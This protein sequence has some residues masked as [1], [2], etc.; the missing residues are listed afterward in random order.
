MAVPHREMATGG[1]QARPGPAMWLLGQQTPEDRQAKAS[2]GLLHGPVW[3]S[4]LLPL[5]LAFCM[6]TLNS[7]FPFTV[8]CSIK[9][10]VCPTYLQRCQCGL[11]AVLLSNRLPCGHGYYNVSKGSL[12]HENMQLF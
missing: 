6:V 7:R 1:A 4:V 5:T 11:L 3:P 12:R 8:A 9:N 2:M 10:R